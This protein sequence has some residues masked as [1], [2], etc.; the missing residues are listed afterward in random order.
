VYVNGNIEA[1]EGGAVKDFAWLTGREAIALI[2][3]QDE[4]QQRVWETI[5]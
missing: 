3:P 1:T 2:K 5:L 4:Q